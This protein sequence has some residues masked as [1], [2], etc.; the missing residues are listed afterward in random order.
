MSV[1]FQN[2]RINSPCC[3]NGT[4][5][6]F[7]CYSHFHY[8]RSAL[9]NLPTASAKKLKKI[10]DCEL[11]CREKPWKPV[12]RMICSKNRYSSQ[13]QNKSVTDLHLFRRRG[14]FISSLNRLLYVAANWNRF[15]N[16]TSQNYIGIHVHKCISWNT[17]PLFRYFYEKIKTK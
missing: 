12:V 10:K 16:S 5:R 4:G 9:S 3:C 7:T 1:S 15:F 8:R 6:R 17:W 11:I 13:N 14:D 2:S